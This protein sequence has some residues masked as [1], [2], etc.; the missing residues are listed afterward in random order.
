MTRIEVA[1]R[2]QEWTGATGP[3]QRY[4][5]KLADDV[6]VTPDETTEALECLDMLRKQVKDRVCRNFC[7]RERR[8]ADLEDA[9]WIIEQLADNMFEKLPEAPIHFTLS[10]TDAQIRQL[11]DGQLKWS[12][13]P[14]QPLPAVGS[15]LNPIPLWKNLKKWPTCKVVGY[16]VEHGWVYL[17]CR[18]VKEPRGA[19]ALW[20]HYC[21]VAGVD[22]VPRNTAQLFSPV[23][24]DVRE[25]RLAKSSYVRL[26]HRAT[27]YEIIVTQVDSERCALTMVNPKRGMMLLPDF[28]RTGVPLDYIADKL[29]INE[30]DA[31]GIA[32][33]AKVCAAE[34]P[35]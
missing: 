17:L 13:T 9:Q 24:K 5:K 35:E 33:A 12:G 30:V 25:M 31:E 14:G 10:M 4:A 34:L 22:I 20:G 15:V 8:K 26:G 23:Y 1:K 16:V 32:L 11:D 29:N 19:D 18:F 21:M 6:A 3:L 7:D 27:N 2:L 28:W